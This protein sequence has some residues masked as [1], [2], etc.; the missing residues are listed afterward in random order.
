MSSVRVSATPGLTGPGTSITFRVTPVSLAPGRDAAILAKYTIGPKCIQVQA[1]DFD[2][3]VTLSTV[4]LCPS[5]GPGTVS[6]GDCRPAAMSQAWARA[7]SHWWSSGRQTCLCFQI[8]VYN[9]PQYV[10]YSPE[11]VTTWCCNKIYIQYICQHVQFVSC[12]DVASGNIHIHVD[13]R[14]SA[15][16]AAP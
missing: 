12:C 3:P 10:L 15:I 9:V 5:H 11:I 13:L 2:V 16:V 14:C 6:C 4:M 1:S 7:W 8:L